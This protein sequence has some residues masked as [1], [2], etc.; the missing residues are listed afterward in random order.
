MIELYGEAACKIGSTVL[1][2][3]EQLAELRL[4]PVGCPLPAVQAPWSTAVLFV[5]QK[6]TQLSLHV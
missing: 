5:Q 6:H 3:G 4:R 1:V 2:T